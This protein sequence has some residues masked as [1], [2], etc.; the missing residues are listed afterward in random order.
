MM[1]IPS[2]SAVELSMDSTVNTGGTELSL[3]QSFNSLSAMAKS[4]MFGLR[5]ASSLGSPA[6]SSELLSLN[7]S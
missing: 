7:E 2:V 4:V 3:A 1:K 5:R 6:T